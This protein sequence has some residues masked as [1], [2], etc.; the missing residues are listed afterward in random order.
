[1]SPP[2]EIADGNTPLDEDDAL[3][4]I[5]DHIHT[6]GEL[7]AWE[8]ANIAEARVWL[9]R[10]RRADVLDTAFLVELHK[11]MFGQTWQ[12]AGRHRTI[13]TTISP[14]HWSEVPALMRNL[15]DD[16][17]AQFDASERAD[18]EL[19]NMAM[20]FHHR[21]VR[22][23]PWPNGNGRHAR[24]STDLLLAQWNRH[25]FEWGAGLQKPGEARTRYL[26]ALRR[27]DSGDFTK[28]RAFLA[29]PVR[30]PQSRKPQRRR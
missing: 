8:A 17:R 25:P 27:A 9:A 21:L 11:R 20:R 1:V 28:L 15:V 3:A 18:D 6:R 26:E 14:Y 16:T 10:R 13:D 23:H 5:P 19:D 4:L 29:R 7:N 24:E 22:I 30:V 12:W 2:E